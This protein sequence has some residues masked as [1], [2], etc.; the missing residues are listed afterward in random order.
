MGRPRLYNT[1]EE[2]KAAK[3]AKSKRY[4]ARFVV[5]HVSLKKILKNLSRRR[6]HI[7]EQRRKRYHKHCK[8][9]QNK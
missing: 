7:N 5:D 1:P 4:Y 3:A 9:T 6:D 8:K 2:T